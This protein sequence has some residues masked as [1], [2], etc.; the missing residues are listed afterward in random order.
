MAAIR[1]ELQL[2]GIEEHRPDV[3]FAARYPRAEKYIGW[4]ML[5]VMQLRA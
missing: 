1:A 5:V 4:P 3:D 2:M